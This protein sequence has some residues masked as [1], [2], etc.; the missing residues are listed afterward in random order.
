MNAQPPLEVTHDGGQTWHNL[1]LPVLPGAGKD[2]LIQTMPPVFFGKNGLL[3][4]Q[5]QGLDLYVTYDGGQTWTPTKLVTS[6]GPG[7]FTVNITDIRHVWATN[8]TNLY[9]TSNG[10]QSWTK[11]P[12]TPQPISELSF[13]D[14]NNGWAIGPTNV[15]PGNTKNQPPSLL[16]TTNSG[17][18]WQ[19]VNYSIVPPQKG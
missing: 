4:V 16:H 1:S 12:P 11:L 17:R 5:D 2:D 3:P 18:T 15:T 9:A 7:S 14:A 19:A 10:G 13:V 8:G 6:N